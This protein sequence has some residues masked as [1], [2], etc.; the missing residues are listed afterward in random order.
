MTFG[1]R[2]NAVHIVLEYNIVL[3]QGHVRGLLERPG[4]YIFRIVAK[5][6]A[7][8]PVVMRDF[9]CGPESF[10]LT[11]NQHVLQGHFPL[12]LARVVDE[13]AARHAMCATG[14]QVARQ[15]HNHEVV[16]LLTYLGLQVAAVAAVSGTQKLLAALRDGASLSSGEL[17]VIFNRRLS[18][19]ASSLGSPCGCTVSI[20]TN[21]QSA[22]AAGLKLL[23]CVRSEGQR[24]WCRR[25]K[26][27]LARAQVRR[28]RSGKQTFFKKRHGRPS[29]TKEKQSYGG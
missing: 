16:M 11:R 14:V 19:S 3:E 1:V 15:L 12:I 7:D 22:L 23:R 20:F 27:A 26:Y 24:F 13:P 28:C 8:Q 18:I 5:A 10:F 21:G 6:G 4:F 17:T 25:L 29:S 9:A 2:R